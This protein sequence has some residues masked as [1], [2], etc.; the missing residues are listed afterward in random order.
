MISQYLN[1]FDKT[2]LFSV[3]VPP[4][5]GLP[6]KGTIIW[7]HGAFEHCLRYAVPM[8][9]FANL[10]YHCISFDLRGHG[11][12]GGERMY[13]KN[14]LDYS[15]ALLA[16][17]AHYRSLKMEPLYMIAH[18]MGGAVAVRTLQEFDKEVKFKKVILTSPFI[19]FKTD[20]PLWKSILASVIV[21]IYPQFS[22][23]ADLDSLFLS[24]D[25]KIAE[26]YMQD[27]KVNKI[28]TAGWFVQIKIHQKVIFEKA[29]SLQSPIHIFQAGDDHIVDNN[30]STLFYSL[31]KMNEKSLF[32]YDNFYHEILNEVNNERVFNDIYNILKL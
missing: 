9:H 17:I 11:Q 19:G 29:D 7:V 25:L 2:K 32:K 12:S 26:D 21:K 10:G 16:V 22:L 13:V 20:I 15:K 6:K 3:S 8:E 23:P 5:E 28:A 14:F 31:L 30:A 27:P 18:S 4:A 1:S 24:H